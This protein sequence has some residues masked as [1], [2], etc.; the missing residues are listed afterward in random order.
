M[1]INQTTMSVTFHFELTYEEYNL[2]VRS[3]AAA[4]G[5]PVKFVDE[6]TELEALNRRM[7]EQQRAAVAEVLRPIDWKLQSSQMTAEDATKAAADKIAAK[8]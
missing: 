2:L 5:Y 6:Q 3:I 8:R 1:K 7:I 4:A